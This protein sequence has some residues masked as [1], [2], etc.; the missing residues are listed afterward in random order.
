M[1]KLI[2]LLVCALAM[3]AANAEPKKLFARF[4]QPSEA[5]T[6]EEGAH[7]EKFKSQPA[8]YA[9]VYAAIGLNHAALLGDEITVA[10]PDGA[11]V[12]YKGGPK[13]HEV[14]HNAKGHPAH[15][16]R[17]RMW[18]GTTG[19]SFLHI[20]IGEHGALRGRVFGTNNYILTSAPGGRVVVF[21]ETV[22]H[23]MKDSWGGK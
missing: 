5:L 10:M 15:T 14:Q 12:T 21:A 13:F 19:L 6:H 3:T 4:L 9:G 17:F 1:N 22:P 20:A 23:T 16:S 8:L 11:V 18:S 2:A 7:V